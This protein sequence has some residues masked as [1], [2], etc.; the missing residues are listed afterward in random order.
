MRSGL[1]RRK[2]DTE[3][4]YPVSIFQMRSIFDEELLP[5]TFQSAPTPEGEAERGEALSELDEPR[6]AVVSFAR[7]EAGPMTYAEAAARM[8]DLNNL[9]IAGLCIVTAE[10][11]SKI[12]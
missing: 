2:K 1:I 9:R 12:R 4:P 11:A 6:W 5:A 3:A 8:T 10:A 7:V